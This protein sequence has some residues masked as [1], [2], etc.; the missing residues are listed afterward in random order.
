VAQLY[1]EIGVG[2]SDRRRPDPRIAHALRA[3]LG[4]ARTVVNV[5][6]GTGS[7]ESGDFRVVA[8]EPSLE[9]IGQRP[10]GAAPV[11]R[12]SAE[13]LPFSDASFDAA[14]VVLTLHHWPDQ[15]G[16]LAELVR[17]ARSRVV[18]LSFVTEGS[19]FW[20]YDYF[21]EIPEIDAVTMP[22]EAELG[23]TLGPFECT[24]LPIP[25]DCAD[26]FL[27]AYWRRPRAY[28]D[29]DVRRAISAFSRIEGV[30]EGLERLRADL[31]DGRWDER[32]GSLMDRTELDLGYR[33][34][35]AEL[36]KT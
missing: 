22:G 1:D 34:I 7:Y 2:Y 29:P 28:L 24:P 14:L 6:A 3:A 17:V 23:R 30:D 16:G 35:V 27:G 31:D 5:G 4:D 18:I 25:H 15:P 21:P 8:V 11:V 20:L 9:M 12:A 33:V 13:R 32:Y 26:G 36:P 10:R 19:V